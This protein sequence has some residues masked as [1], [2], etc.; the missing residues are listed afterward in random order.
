[1]AINSFYSVDLTSTTAGTD[2]VEIVGKKRLSISGTFVATVTIQ[3]LDHAGNWQT[4]PTT[5]TSA[6]EGVIDN[7]RDPAQYRAKLSAYTSG[8]VH[9]EIG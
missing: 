1:M 2:V 6:Y 8:T 3:R 7:G 4:L 5:F 9:V